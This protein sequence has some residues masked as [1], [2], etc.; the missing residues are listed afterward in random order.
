L[1]P[2]RVGTQTKFVEPEQ[3]AMFMDSKVRR[4][5]I[6]LQSA[7]GKSA[8]LMD[9]VDF[10]NSATVL[11]VDVLQNAV[12][13]ELSYN[14]KPGPIVQP[15]KYKVRLPLDLVE[16][17]CLVGEFWHIYL[18]GKLIRIHPTQHSPSG[19]KD[20]PFLFRH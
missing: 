1:F 2:L 13:F 19:L 5:S 18:R 11:S 15:N 4:V 7:V 17:A 3:M 16:T 10:H 6:L 20:L 14:D 8:V 9:G 12:D